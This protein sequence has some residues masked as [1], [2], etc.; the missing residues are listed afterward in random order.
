MW[1]IGI[2]ERTRKLKMNRICREVTNGN[3]VDAPDGLTIIFGTE[4]VW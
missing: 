3:L 2:V 4:K 1:H